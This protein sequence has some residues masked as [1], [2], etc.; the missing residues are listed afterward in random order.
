M[1]FLCMAAVTALLCLL[2]VPGTMGWNVY[3]LDPMRLHES[4]PSWETH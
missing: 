3:C 4:H 2:L 1:G